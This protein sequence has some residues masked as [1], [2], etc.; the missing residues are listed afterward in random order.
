MN[1]KSFSK[2]C[3]AL[4]GKE[5]RS[6]ILLFSDKL[7]VFIE[8]TGED[9]VMRWAES[10]GGGSIS[11]FPHQLPVPAM[12]HNVTYQLRSVSTRKTSMS[13][14]IKLSEE[15][16][17]KERFLMVLTY[18]FVD[19]RLYCQGDTRDSWDCN[20]YW[21]INLDGITRSQMSH[22]PAIGPLSSL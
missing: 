12:C 7:Y 13:A 2:W 14:I 17:K 1:A 8:N 3:T 11:P 22:K 18:K 10:W 4:G 21:D 6:S 15:R 16:K 9:F 20:I 19:L 5:A